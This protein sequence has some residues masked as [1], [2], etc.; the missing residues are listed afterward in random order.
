MRAGIRAVGD[1]GGSKLADRAEAK[2]QQG[3]SVLGGRTYCWVISTV[4]VLM[5]C[6]ESRHVL[7]AEEIPL[8][9]AQLT[10]QLSQVPV[11]RIDQIMRK[12]STNR[13]INDS[14]LEAISRELECSVSN[15]EESP[16]ISYAFS[17]LQ[18][19]R[20]HQLNLCLVLGVL[21]GQGTYLEKATLLYEVYDETLA[22]MIDDTQ[23]S[24]FLNDL[25]FVVL[26]VLGALVD[27]QVAAKSCEDYLNSCF[28]ALPRVKAQ[29]MRRIKTTDAI[30]L[31][32]F[33][34]SLLAFDNGRILEPHELRSFL[35]SEQIKKP[36]HL[37]GKVTRLS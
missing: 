11:Q 26:N 16:K 5:G 2:R 29:L 28:E 20:G 24:M 35:Y 37:F 12:F 14:Q 9:E 18:D 7:R 19:S 31:E 1:G 10:L 36:T 21:C 13:H 6:T 3:F 23:L 8:V 30:T 32:T 17:K 25:F 22:G 15:T 27:T 34:H 33:V 4:I